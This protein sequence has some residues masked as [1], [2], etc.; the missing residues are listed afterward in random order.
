MSDTEMASDKPETKIVLLED[1]GPC[2]PIGVLEGA[3]LAKDMDAKAWKMKHERALGEMRSKHKDANVAQYV[4]M[5]LSTMYNNLGFFDFTNMSPS[6]R[7][8]RIGRMFMGDVF[9]AYMWLRCQALGDVFVV[10]VTCPH[11]GF[12]YQLKADLKTV[13]VTCADSIEAVKWRYD[14]LDPFVIQDQEITYFEMGPCKW[15]TLEAG[16]CGGALNIGAAKAMIIRGSIW[17]APEL[18]KGA[19]SEEDLDE[20]TKR[21]LEAMTAAIDS[22]HVGPDMSIEDSCKRCNSDFKAS[23]DWGYDSFFSNSSRLDL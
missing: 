10:H 2:L 17:K 4:G 1:L 5:V 21:D 15:R 22:H 3:S 11:C 19:L 7:R 18:T 16:F 20:M 8:G 12:K 9:Y 6:D 23:I 14:L 13:E